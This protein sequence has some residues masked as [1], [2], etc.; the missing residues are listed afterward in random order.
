MATSLSFDVVNLVI[1]LTGSYL[2]TSMRDLNDLAWVFRI[3]GEVTLSDTSN[4]P[5]PTGVLT[6]E[7]AMKWKFAPRGSA[8]QDKLLARPEELEEG[9]CTADSTADEEDGSCDDGEVCGPGLAC[10]VGIG[11]KCSKCPSTHSKPSILE[12]NSII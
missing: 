3:D 10:V 11:R 9:S 2:D 7:V 6:V 12:L 5:V 4:S 8:M 1:K